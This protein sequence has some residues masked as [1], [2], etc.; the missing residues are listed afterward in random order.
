MDGAG[1]ADG[2]R[3]ASPLTATGIE[4]RRLRTRFIPW[5]QIRDIQVVERVT[6][7][8]L[9]VLGNRTAGRFGSRPGRGAR[10]VAAIRVQRANGRRRELAM[11]VAWENAPDPGFTRK[12][13]VIKDH[14]RAA[15]GQASAA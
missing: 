13:D 11:P 2:D 12:A 4:S 7:A 8:Q 9:A 5:A 1:H 3:S 14:W 10:K 15:A 6:V